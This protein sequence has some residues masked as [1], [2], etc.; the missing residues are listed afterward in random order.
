[1]HASHGEVE[2]EEDL[3]VLRDI[4]GQR[5]VALVLWMHEILDREASARDVVFR[6]LVV[7]FD[8]LDAEEDESQQNGER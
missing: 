7:V 2:E 1:M 3:R 5:Y 6:V 8:G 4:R